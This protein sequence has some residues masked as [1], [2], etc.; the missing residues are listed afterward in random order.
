MDP[1]KKRILLVEDFDDSRFSLSKL[2]QI[3]GYDVIEAVDGAQ[4]ISLAETASPDLILMDLS[5]PV[6]DGLTATRSI[7]GQKGMTHIPIIALSGHEMADLQSEAAEA[8]CTDYVMK[9]IDFDQLN[10]LVSKHLDS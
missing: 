5:L 9:P 8:G 4:A 10:S 2:L 3:E 1:Q 6:V 7:R